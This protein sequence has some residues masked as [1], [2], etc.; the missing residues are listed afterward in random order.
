MD[1]NTKT[2]PVLAPQTYQHANAIQ[3]NSTGD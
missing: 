3:E 2:G 1:L